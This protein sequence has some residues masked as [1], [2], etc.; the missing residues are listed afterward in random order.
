MWS[1]YMQN[2]SIQAQIGR[3]FLTHATWGI[4]LEDIMLSEINQSQKDK[5]CTIPPEWG[6]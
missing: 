5:C 1:I 3:K 2:N 6:T 4:N